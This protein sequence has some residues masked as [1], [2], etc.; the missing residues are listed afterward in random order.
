MKVKEMIQL[1]YHIFDYYTS[2]KGRSVKVE[3]VP[4]TT[5]SFKSLGKPIQ[6]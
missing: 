5:L 4:C 6:I 3:K 1:G 2:K